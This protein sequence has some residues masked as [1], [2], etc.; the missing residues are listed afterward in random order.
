KVGCTAGGA[1]LH[2]GIPVFANWNESYPGNWHDWVNQAVP[3]RDPIT[4]NVIG[5]INV[6]GFLEIVHPS[7]LDL[8][9]RAAESIE[10]AIQQHDWRSRALVLERFQRTLGL[11]SNDACFAVDRRGRLIAFN[12]IAARRFRIANH[13]VEVGIERLTPLSGLFDFKNVHDDGFNRRAQPAAGVDVVEPDAE[14]ID[15]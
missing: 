15:G 7:I 2:D 6:A 10:L 1:S 12:E 13:H 4:H 9:L 11:A 5:G 8:T 3:L 14:R